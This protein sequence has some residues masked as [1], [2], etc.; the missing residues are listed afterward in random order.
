MLCIHDSPTESSGACHGLIPGRSCD[1]DEAGEYWMELMDTHDH[2]GYLPLPFRSS[3]TTHRLLLQLLLPPLDQS[4]SNVAA[5][6]HGLP[7]LE[8]RSRR[9]Q[10]RSGPSCLLACFLVMSA[11]PYGLF[12]CHVKSAISQGLSLKLLTAV[13]GSDSIECGTDKENPSGGHLFGG[14]AAG[15]NA[16]PPSTREGMGTHLLTCQRYL[17][18]QVPADKKTTAACRR[19]A[20]VTAATPARSRLRLSDSR[21]SSLLSTLT[22]PG[23]NGWASPCSFPSADEVVYLTYRIH[24]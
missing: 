22:V 18:Q 10:Q 4:V 20:A 1:R 17:T 13:T 9:L 8:S 3:R 7:I 12:H 16:T 24:R 2:G 19:G 14:V 15:S 23:T 5:W 11:R 6:D 21:C